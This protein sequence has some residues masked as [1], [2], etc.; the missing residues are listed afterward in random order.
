MT[1]QVLLVQRLRRSIPHFEPY[2]EADEVEGARWGVV[3]ADRL[4]A[5]RA[6][7]SPDSTQAGHS[8]GMHS[9]DDSS[10]GAEHD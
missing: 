2:W 4:E 6:E 7:A 5:C 8:A 3:E 9:A 1:V 10:P